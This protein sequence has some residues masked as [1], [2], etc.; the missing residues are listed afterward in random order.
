[1]QGDGFDSAPQAPDREPNTEYACPA[2]GLPVGVDPAQPV[3]QCSAC[4]EQFFAPGQDHVDSDEPGQVEPAGPNAPD[5]AAALNEL[6]IK[7]VSNLR[8]GLI[9]TQSWW[10]IGTGTCLVSAAMLVQMIVQAFGARLWM[11]AIGYGLGVGVSLMLAFVCV[12]RIIDTGREIRQTRMPEPLT[13][14][15]LSTLSDGSQRWTQLEQLAND[16]P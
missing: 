7:Q 2:C 4:G 14:P 9:R 3:L 15:D 13:P 6:R 16:K 5:D 10:I 8:R 11:F 12:R 1:M